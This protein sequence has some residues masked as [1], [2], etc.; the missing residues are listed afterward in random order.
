MAVNYT[1]VIRW[2]LGGSVSGGDQWSIGGFLQIGTPASS[3]GATSAQM[4]TIAGTIL[5]NFNTNVW[6]AT[7]G[8]KAKNG[9]GMTLF[10]CNTYMYDGGALVAQGSNTITA[11][12]GTAA[13]PHP[14]YVAHCMTLKTAQNTRSGRG[15]CYLPATGITLDATTM[16]VSS[17]SNS[18]NVTQLAAFFTAANTNYTINLGSTLGSSAVWSTK[19]ATPHIITQV[20]GDT[21]PDTQRGRINRI[22]ATSQNSASV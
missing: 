15:R 1:G 19:D 18:Q 5:G 20:V 7:N 16:Q 22:S 2:T 3:A 4:N 14:A 21:L 10:S 9:A 13:Q 17:T 6:S 12:P 11:V 8:L